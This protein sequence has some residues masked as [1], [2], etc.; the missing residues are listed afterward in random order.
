MGK[1]FHRAEFL[2]L[3]ADTVTSTKR[4]QVHFSKRLVTVQNNH[5]GGYDLLFA[6][7]STAVC[8]V[9]L[10]ADGVRS[11]VRASMTR[12]ALSAMDSEEERAAYP[13]PKVPGVEF[14]FFE[15]VTTYPQPI[16]ADFTADDGRAAWRVQLMAVVAAYKPTIRAILAHIRDSPNDPFLFHCTGKDIY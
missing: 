6:D 13:S 11:A 2:N 3:W 15:R 5:S 12:F 1:S 16:P 4:A 7:G 8:D 14:I 10:G 9:L